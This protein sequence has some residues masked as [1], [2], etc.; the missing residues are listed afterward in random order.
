MA[1]QLAVKVD[2]KNVTHIH[3]TDKLLYLVWI[4]REIIT[5]TYNSYFSINIGEQVYKIVLLNFVLE[6]AP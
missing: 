2:V 3:S 1:E 6:E 5:R 4:L